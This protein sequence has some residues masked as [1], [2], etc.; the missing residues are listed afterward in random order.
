MEPLED[1][2]DPLRV[3]RL[4]ADAVIGQPSMPGLP[5]CAADAGYLSAMEWRLVSGSLAEPE[6]AI[7]W[8]RM[9]CPLIQG[10]L[11]SPL[12]RVL[13]AADSGNGISRVLDLT[14][15]P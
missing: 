6:P 14:T 12:S 4:D 7:A 15:N 2:E 10:A 5:G 9:R 8:L 1:H 3:T 13:A 11:T